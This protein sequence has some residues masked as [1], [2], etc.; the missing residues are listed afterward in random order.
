MSL[1]SIVGEEDASSSHK[2]V[3]IEARGGSWL[4]SDGFA[5]Y[6]QIDLQQAE[7]I[8]VSFIYHLGFKEFL[9]D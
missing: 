3:I 4:Y 7:T 9:P 2:F 1:S 5:P 6:L 8:Q